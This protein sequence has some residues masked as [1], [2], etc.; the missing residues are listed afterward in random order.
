VEKYDRKYVKLKRAKNMEAVMISSGFCPP[1]RGSGPAKNH[2]N[3]AERRMESR[4]Q[5]G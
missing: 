4:S 3:G 5:R 1:K 2:A